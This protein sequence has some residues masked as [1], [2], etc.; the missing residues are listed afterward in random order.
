MASS[1]A[2]SDG[3]GEDSAAMA[4][5][6]LSSEAAAP[7]KAEILLEAFR[8]MPQHMKWEFFARFLKQWPPYNAQ[9]QVIVDKFITHFVHAGSDESRGAV[10]A[11]VQS[12]ISECAEFRRQMQS[13]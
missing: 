12:K 3:G 7:V 10:L 1:G 4:S 5:G 2:S 6:D 9:Q 8:R 11:G 13:K